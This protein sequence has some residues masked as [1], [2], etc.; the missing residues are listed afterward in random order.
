MTALPLQS[1]PLVV[2]K[3]DTDNYPLSLFLQ[4]YYLAAYYSP[5]SEVSFNPCNFLSFISRIKNTFAL[6]LDLWPRLIIAL[7]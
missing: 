5:L 1:A 7:L 2:L 4:Y 3:R 6:Q